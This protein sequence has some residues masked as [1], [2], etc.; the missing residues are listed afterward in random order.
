MTRLAK[1]PG[2]VEL[3]RIGAELAPHG[4][5]LARVEERPC[6]VIASDGTR[7]VQL[8]VA[9]VM[10][11]RDRGRAVAFVRDAVASGVPA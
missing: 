9:E 2:R 1:Y 8:D 5:T 11:A 4:V 3:A 6:H 7:R 10:T